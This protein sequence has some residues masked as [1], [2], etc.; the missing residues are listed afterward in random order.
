MFGSNFSKICAVKVRFWASKQINLKK[1]SVK[2]D[3][4]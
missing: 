3:Q 4:K 2:F 1:K